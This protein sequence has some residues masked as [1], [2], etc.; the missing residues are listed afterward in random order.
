MDALPAGLGAVL[1]GHREH[2][3]EATILTL[4][5]ESRGDLQ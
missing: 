2:R 3:R 5:S 4:D 1:T